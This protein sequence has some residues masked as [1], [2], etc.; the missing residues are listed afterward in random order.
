MG[1]ILGKIGWVVLETIT[2][3][4]APFVALYWRVKCGLGKCTLIF[5][6]DVLRKSRCTKCLEE[7]VF[8]ITVCCFEEVEFH[9]PWNSVDELV[10][11]KGGSHEPG[12]I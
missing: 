6:E 11:T 10:K 12:K 1:K 5:S 2:S 3:I 7:T 4:L 9:R 8:A